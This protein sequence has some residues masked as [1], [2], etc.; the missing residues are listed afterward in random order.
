MRTE[1]G[2][3]C[4]TIY[5]TKRRQLAS[6]CEFGDLEGELIRDRLVLGTID[7][8]ARARMLREPKLDLNKAI[9]MCRNSEITK[10]QLQNFTYG[11]ICNSCK[12]MNHFAEVCQQPKRSSK[13]NMMS[14]E[15]SSE[16]EE[17]VHGVERTVGTVKSRG[18]KWF[19]R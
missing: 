19:A 2:R 5:I 10:S 16:S 8:S 15:L 7:A 4:G 14:D 12:K 9:E 18:E 17:S 1:P 13:V 3:D 11:E 6:T